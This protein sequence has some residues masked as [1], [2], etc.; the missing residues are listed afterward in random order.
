MIEKL[1]SWEPYARSVMRIIVAYAFFLHG[2]RH[3]L[4]IFPVPAR[5]RAINMA[6]DG[7]PAMFGVIELAGGLLLLLGLFTRP[8][9]V[10]LCAQAAL[11]YLYTSVPRGPWP[12]RNGG[13]EALIYFLV[14][15]YIAATDGG[16]WSL[17]RA[18]QRRRDRP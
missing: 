15:A 9:A 12:I 2:F 8:I 16:E 17:D 3:L 5:T 1:E 10:L 13:N 18:L 14:F 11:A 6:L 7:L 4:G